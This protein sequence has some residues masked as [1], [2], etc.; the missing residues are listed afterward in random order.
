[1]N[2][3]YPEENYD[4]K[5]SRKIAADVYIDDR[6]LGGFQ[7]WSEVWKMMNP[8]L[9]ENSDAYAPSGKPGN[10]FWKKLFR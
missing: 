8:E 6:N 4:G 7:G 10:S 1:V 9:H 3:N 5:I 2:N